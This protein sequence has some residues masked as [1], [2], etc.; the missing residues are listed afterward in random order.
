M[1]HNSERLNIKSSSLQ[2]HADDSTE[3]CLLQS[4]IT[5][6]TASLNDASLKIASSFLPGSSADPCHAQ[7]TGRELTVGGFSSLDTPSSFL[8]SNVGDSTELSRTSKSCE[9]DKDNPRNQLSSR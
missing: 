6:Q 4:R 7:S 8:R 1:A 9:S 5:E 2:G 3:P